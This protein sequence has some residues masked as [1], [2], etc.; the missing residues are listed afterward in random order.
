MLVQWISK[1]FFIQEFFSDIFNYFHYLKR[2]DSLYIEESPPCEVF[3]M[4]ITV[5]SFV[6][7]VLNNNYVPCNM[8]T[9]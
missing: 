4:M 7:A 2:I 9:N 3:N 5:T 6:L 1:D 8:Q